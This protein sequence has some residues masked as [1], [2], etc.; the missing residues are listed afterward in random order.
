MRTLP[1]SSRGLR[2]NGFLDVVDDDLAVRHLRRI[3]ED[4]LQL[5]VAH[6]FGS[7]TKARPVRYALAFHTQRQ[8]G[9]SANSS[10]SCRGG[11]RSTRLGSLLQPLLPRAETA[12]HGSADGIC[13][14]HAAP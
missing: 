6:P 13:D 8:R 7:V 5:L 14:L 2:P 11:S 3:L 12:R 9:G 4:P 1:A 10:S